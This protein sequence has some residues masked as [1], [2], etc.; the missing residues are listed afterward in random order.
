MFKN[1]TNI[2]FWLSTERVHAKDFI[3]VDI[4]NTKVTHGGKNQ[5][6][7]TLRR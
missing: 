1:L 3:Y 7:G 6:A 4:R 2:L 5:T